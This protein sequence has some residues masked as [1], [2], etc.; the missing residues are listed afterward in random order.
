MNSDSIWKLYLKYKIRYLLSS[1]SCREIEMFRNKQKCIVCLAADYGNLGD[2]AITY[3]QTKFLQSRFPNYEIVDFPISK[4]LFNLKAL[5]SICSPDDIITIVGG[6][7]MGDMYYDIELLRLL[8]VSKFPN[9]KIVSFPQTIDYSNSS[10][11]RNL[12]KLSRRIY[13]N[14]PNLYLCVREEVSFDKIKCLYPTCNICLV[15]DIVLS[16][17]ERYPIMKRKGITLCLRNDKERGYLSDT[18]ISLITNIRKDYILYEY[19]THICRHNMTIVE[20]EKELYLIWNR[21]R[22]SEWIITDRL[23]GMIF[24][25]ITGTPAI[26]FPNSNFKIE[27]S[28]E[29][30]KECGYIFFIRDKNA[31]ILEILKSKPRNSGFEKVHEKIVDNI[32]NIPL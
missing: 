29:W 10:H 23:H 22:S 20:R 32:K 12:I 7:N 8:I 17:D 13:S 14:H 26:V 2:V 4:T 18:I 9:N 3:A 19:D 21:F 6:G 16:L 27:K 11:A 5:K 25:Y 30:I 15:P 28:F 31:N 24:A 1:S